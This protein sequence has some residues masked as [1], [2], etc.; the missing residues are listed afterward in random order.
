MKK[1]LIEY[2]KIERD[3]K[4]HLQWTKLKNLNQGINEGNLKQD[5]LSRSK[6]EW[7]CHDMFDP[8]L[9]LMS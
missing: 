7:T 8:V 9:K 2:L 5:R 3:M 6:V 1:H 4:R